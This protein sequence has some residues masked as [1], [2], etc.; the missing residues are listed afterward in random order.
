M[1]LHVNTRNV[2]HVIS[3]S[4]AYVASWGDLLVQLSLQPDGRGH[5]LLVRAGLEGIPLEVGAVY[6]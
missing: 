6:V 2:Y 4:T 3:Y 5:V 1:P